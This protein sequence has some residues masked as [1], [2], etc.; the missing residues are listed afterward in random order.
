MFEALAVR[1]DG[2]SEILEFSSDNGLKVLQTAVE[3]LIEYVDFS[4]QGMSM[5][6]NEEGLYLP[7]EKN[8]L[9]SVLYSEEFSVPNFVIKGTVVFVGATNEDGET[10]GLSRIQKFVLSEMVKAT[11]TLLD[12][13]YTE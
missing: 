4:T 10:T 11:K 12:S 3:G 7:L 1:P 8:I 5:V 2:T 13:G 9:A 6:I